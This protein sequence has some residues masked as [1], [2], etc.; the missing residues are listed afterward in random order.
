[1]VEHVFVDERRTAVAVC[2]YCSQEM[3]SA[4]RCSLTPIVIAGESYSPV[5]YTP[6]PGYRRARARCGDC[7]VLP[8]SVHHHGFDI[9]ECPACFG[10]SISCE[11]LWAGEEHLAEDWEEGLRSSSTTPIM[12]VMYVWEERPDRVYRYRRRAR[13]AS[14]GA[15]TRLPTR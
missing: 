4:A 13:M 10:Q 2:S 15:A 5:P 7:G 6:E 8:G 14:S 12:S 1:L 3:L 11:C 9:E